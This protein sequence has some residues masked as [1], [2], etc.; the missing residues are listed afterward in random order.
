[1]F[2]LVSPSAS[3]DR[4]VG[5]LLELAL[6]DEGAVAPCILHSLIVVDS[7]KGWLEYI[8]W[9]EQDVKARVSLP[10]Y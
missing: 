9:L 2:L 5:R 10:S 3:I 4:N 8:A 1:M 6:S 7:V